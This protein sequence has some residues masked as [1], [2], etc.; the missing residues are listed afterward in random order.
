VVKETAENLSFVE[1]KAITL[2]V[3]LAVSRKPVNTETSS[4]GTRLKSAVSI[5]Q[6]PENL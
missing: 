5:S 6:H 3:S 1:T 4:W 2:R